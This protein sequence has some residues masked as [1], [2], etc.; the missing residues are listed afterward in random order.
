[1]PKVAMFPPDLGAEVASDPSAS[2]RPLLG[3]SLQPRADLVRLAAEVVEPGQCCQRLESKNTFEQGRRLVA[4]RAGRLRVAPRFR[5]QPA[6]DQPGDDRV[7][8]N[9]ADPG[10]VGTRAGPEVG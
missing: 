9:A 2:G 7:C 8:G 1:M 3:H 5:D 10:D 4:D 6:L